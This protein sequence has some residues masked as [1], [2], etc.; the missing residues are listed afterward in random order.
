V[1]VIKKPNNMTFVISDKTNN[2]ACFS[3]DRFYCILNV[4]TS[5]A[6]KIIAVNNYIIHIHHSKYNSILFNPLMPNGH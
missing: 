4:L 6:N 2:E 5:F 1:Y 3:S